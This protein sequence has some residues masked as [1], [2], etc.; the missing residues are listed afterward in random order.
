MVA[1]IERT[2]RVNVSHHNVAKPWRDNGLRPQQQG[3]YKGLLGSAVRLKGRRRRRVVPAPARRSVV[4][5]IDGR[6]K[7]PG[8]DRHPTVVQMTFD[9]TE[10]RAHDSS[11]PAR[12]TGITILLSG[13]AAV[14]HLTE[15][16]PTPLTL[17]QRCHPDTGCAFQEEQCLES[18]D[19]V[20]QR[21]GHCWR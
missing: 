3:N 13:H 18:R 8:V 2:E 14:C 15:N 21:C 19:I 10:K 12:H 5:S 1:F 17:T 6:P 11:A 20:G 9:V 4:L 7:I 16:G